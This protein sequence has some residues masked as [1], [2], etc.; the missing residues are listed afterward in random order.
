MLEQSFFHARD[1][2]LF[3]TIGSS[4]V[5]QP[6]AML[7]IEAKRSGARLVLI[8]LSETPYDRIMDVILHGPAGPTVEAVMQEFRKLEQ[9]KARGVPNA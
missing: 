7:P 6:A 4:L 8:N 1:C 5:V 3:L 2:D 9:A